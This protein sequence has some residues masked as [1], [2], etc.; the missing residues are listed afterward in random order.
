MVHRQPVETRRE[1]VAAARGLD[2]DRLHARSQVIAPFTAI[3]HLGGGGEKP[4][5]DELLARVR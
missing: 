4:L 2:G 1:H 5:I 3:A